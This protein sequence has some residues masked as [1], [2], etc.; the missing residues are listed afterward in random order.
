MMGSGGAP[1]PISSG[2]NFRP[3][4]RHSIVFESYFCFTA[5]LSNVEIY[6]GDA[7]YLG[8]RILSQWNQRQDYAWLIHAGQK[9]RQ[10][11]FPILR[12]GGPPTTPVEEAEDGET[13]W[14]ADL[15]RDDEDDGLG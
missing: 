10:R 13:V 2:P 8:F 7:P 12:D 4:P 6:P 1:I 15:R 14:P 3:S 9:T 5:E 11:D